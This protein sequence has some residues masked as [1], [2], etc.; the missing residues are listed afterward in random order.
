MERRDIFIMPVQGLLISFDGPSVEGR[1]DQLRSVSLGHHVIFGSHLAISFTHHQ[2]G[3]D[4]VSS[5]RSW[6]VQQVHVWV[7]G[8]RGKVM[9]VPATRLPIRVLPS[10]DR[11][12][13]RINCGNRRPS[14]VRVFKWKV[15]TASSHD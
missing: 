14:N 4:R 10:P 6:T 9:N 8:K 3:S 13:V 2:A 15:Y 1:S 11:H 5:C 12:Q 7:C